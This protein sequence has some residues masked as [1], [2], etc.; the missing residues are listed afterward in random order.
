MPPTCTTTFSLYSA[1]AGTQ[2]SVHAKEGLYLLSCTSV[3]FVLF[4]GGFLGGL[5]GCVYV[6]MWLGMRHT[7][8]GD[9]GLLTPFPKC[10]DC[11]FAHT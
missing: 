5:V 9:F 2:D 4:Y 3:L 1:E 6:Y 10:W 8:K 7:V 11:V